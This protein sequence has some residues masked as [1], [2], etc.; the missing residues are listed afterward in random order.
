MGHR[1][2]MFKH[3]NN[4]STVVITIIVNLYLH[5]STSN[6]NDGSNNIHHNDTTPT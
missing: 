1:I 3:P 5:I 4:D 2:M 6:D